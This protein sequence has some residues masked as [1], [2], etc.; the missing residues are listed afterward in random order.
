MGRTGLDSDWSGRIVA[1]AELPPRLVKSATRVLEV[2]EF[3]DDIQRDATV[4]EVAQALNYPQSSTSMLLRTMASLG[5]LEQNLRDRTFVPSV[6]VSLLGNWV[7]QS[8][9]RDGLLVQTMKEL[10]RATRDTIVLIAQIGL[11]CQY[12]HIIQAISPARLHVTL[13][14]AR[15]VAASGGGYALLS[16]MDDRKAIALLNRINAEAKDGN[17]INRVEFLKKLNE[18]RR[19][20]YAFNLDSVTRGA[21]MMAAPL[22]AVKGQRPLAIGIGGISEVM[23]DREDELAGHLK[24]AIA[25]Y[26]KAQENTPDWLA[27]ERP[28]GDP[29]YG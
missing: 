18:V 28:I 12:I 8:F 3:F 5:Y 20:G 16:L 17:P 29:M 27:Q 25:R 10:N 23:R 1:R 15:P 14:T 19:K 21:G 13:G 2:L 7:D 4:M 6:R 22:P 24:S 11:N 9:V 26:A